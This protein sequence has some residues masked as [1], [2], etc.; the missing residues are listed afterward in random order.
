VEIEGN[1]GPWHLPRVTSLSNYEENMSAEAIGL[2]LRLIM[3]A[4]DMEP[5]EMAD[6]LGIDRPAWSRFTNGQRVIPYD[7]ASRLVERFGVSLDFVILGRIAGMEHS[8][9]ERL[10]RASE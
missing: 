9:V 1:G 10:R 4:F 5:M 8:V 3:R 7:K 6:V 2:R